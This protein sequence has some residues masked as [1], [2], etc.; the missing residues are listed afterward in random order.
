MNGTWT[1]KTGWRLTM[2]GGGQLG[3]GGQREK[4][5]SNCNKTIKYLIKICPHKVAPFFTKW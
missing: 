4:N 2:G 1:W 5:W 3:G